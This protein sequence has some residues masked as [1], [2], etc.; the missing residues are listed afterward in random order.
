[1]RVLTEAG[2][3]RVLATGNFYPGQLSFG[4][5]DNLREASKC[6]VAEF[7]MLEG[8]INEQDRLKIEG[9][10]SHKWGIP[11]P[12]S[13]PW[14]NDAPT[15][16]DV[17]LSGSTALIDTNRTVVPTIINRSPANLKNTSASLTG[18]L[19][20]TGLGILPINPAGVVSTS[21]STI[22][23]LSPPIIGDINAS[24]ISQSSANLR[25]TLI[26]TG[27]ETPIITIVWGDED[28][29][30]DFNNL[31][32]WDFNESLG[33]STAG[34]FSV[35][36]GGLQERTVYFFRVAVSNSIGS[37]H[38]TGCGSICDKFCRPGTPSINFMA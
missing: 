6:Q 13:H 34:P 18:R 14:A 26:S 20:D 2:G 37:V 24:N 21:T 5:F 4:A 22:A 23:G 27:G 28:H 8:L 17:I 1:M 25:G 32:S 33:Y 9:Y 7:I 35:L 29:G 30:S 11:L 15:Y 3:S 10:L 19:V 36:V 38:V 16:G 12:S 31:S